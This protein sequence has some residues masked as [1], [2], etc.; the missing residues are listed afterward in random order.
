M[1]ALT[2]RVG[3]DGELLRSPR[4]AALLSAGNTL[5]PITLAVPMIGNGVG[6]E[7]AGYLLAYGVFV[8]PSI[9]HFY[10]RTG[11]GP[12]GIVLRGAGF[13]AF[14]AGFVRALDVAFGGNRFDESR[15]EALLL[16]GLAVVGLSALFDLATA[17]P[18]TRRANRRRLARAQVSAVRTFGETSPGVGLALRF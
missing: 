7:W 14:T 9:G 5:I 8:G 11:Q 16:G 4:K 6:G 13:V 2:V 17:A 18:A 15:T 1:T 3:V 10:G 12:L